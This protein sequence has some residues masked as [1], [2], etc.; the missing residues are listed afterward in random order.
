M[1]MDL[2]SL[3]P[4]PWPQERSHPQ[5][6]CPKALLVLRT[7]PAGMEEA[8]RAASSV[9]YWTDLLSSPRLRNRHPF[10]V[11]NETLEAKRS[12]R[13]LSH[14][15]RCLVCRVCNKWSCCLFFFFFILTLGV[16]GGGLASKNQKL[17]KRS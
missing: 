8:V 12:G 3:P 14:S 2:I 4:P 5:V 16:W 13:M 9:Q 15:D 10:P 17:N 6:L 7:Q 1:R 11:K